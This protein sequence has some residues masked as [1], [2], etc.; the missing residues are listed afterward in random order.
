VSRPVKAERAFPS[1]GHY[2]FDVTI[3]MPL[4]GL[5]AGYQGRLE[6]IA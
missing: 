1:R 3:A 4:I 2:Y 6:P 5:I